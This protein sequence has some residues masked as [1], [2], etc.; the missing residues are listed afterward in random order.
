M[1]RKLCI[2]H[3]QG[4]KLRV[5][6]EY[7]SIAKIFCMRHSVDVLSLKVS[8]DGVTGLIKSI[9]VLFLWTGLLLM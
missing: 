1:V 3:I 2:L 9:N 7:I 6:T 5:S 4:E 8:M